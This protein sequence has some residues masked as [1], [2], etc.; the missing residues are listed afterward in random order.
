MILLK[1]MFIVLFLNIKYKKNFYVCILRIRFKVVFNLQS[2]KTKFTEHIYGYISLIKF[3]N[4]I[5]G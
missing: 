1:E 2:L 5:Y 4:K 3:M